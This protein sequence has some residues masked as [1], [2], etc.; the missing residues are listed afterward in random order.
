M[1]EI[2]GIC[3]EKGWFWLAINEAC[4]HFGM[5]SIGLVIHGACTHRSLLAYYPWGIFESPFLGITVHRAGYAL[6][7]YSLEML[8]LYLS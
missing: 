5:V 2:H 8:V 3:Y 7:P 6:I 1:Q 4:F